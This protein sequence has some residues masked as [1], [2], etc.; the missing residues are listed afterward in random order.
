M[1]HLTASLCQEFCNHATIPAGGR[2]QWTVRRRG[3]P[4]WALCLTPVSRDGFKR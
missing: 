2:G 4:E 3:S 1:F